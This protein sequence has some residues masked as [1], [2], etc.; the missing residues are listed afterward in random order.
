MGILDANGRKLVEAS[1]ELRAPGDA[2]RSTRLGSDVRTGFHVGRPQRARMEVDLR[3][4]APEETRSGSPD[5]NPLEGRGSQLPGS[6]RGIWRAFGQ[7][8]GEDPPA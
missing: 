8:S 7:N 5:R 6:R 4:F 3:V 2:F 1:L